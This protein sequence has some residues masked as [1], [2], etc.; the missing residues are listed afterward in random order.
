M[1]FFINNIFFVFIFFIFGESCSSTLK[2]THRSVYFRDTYKLK[3][4]KKSINNLFLISRYGHITLAGSAEYLN[5]RVL[6]IKYIGKGS[7]FNK[8]SMIIGSKDVIR[9]DT[10]IIKKKSVYSIRNYDA[11]T[12]KYDIM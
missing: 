3:I 12:G 9:R 5:D 4:K 1:N 8:D 10:L 2:Y 11:K 7:V 6:I